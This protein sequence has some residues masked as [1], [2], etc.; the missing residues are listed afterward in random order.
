VF[1][2]EPISPYLIKDN[3]ALHQF[4]KVL[5][6]LLPASMAFFKSTEEFTTVIGS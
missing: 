1:P 6:P 2:N 4:A 3:L 5:H